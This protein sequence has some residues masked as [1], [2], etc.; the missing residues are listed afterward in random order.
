[1]FIINLIGY[2]LLHFSLEYKLSFSQSQAVI[3][4]FLKKIMD[5][6]K[7]QATKKDISDSPKSP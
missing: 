4:T 1:M 5:K 3:F 2:L 6:L 7:I